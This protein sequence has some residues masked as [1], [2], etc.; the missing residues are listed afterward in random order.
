MTD[1]GHDGG[2]EEAREWVEAVLALQNRIYAK[3]KAIGFLEPGEEDR[4]SHHLAEV[5]FGGSVFASR[6]MPSFLISEGDDLPT[7][8]VDLVEDVREIK[9]AIEAVEGEPLKQMRLPEIADV[10]EHAA[11]FAPMQHRPDIA[12]EQ[13]QAQQGADGLQLFHLEFAFAVILSPS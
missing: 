6:M 13:Q 4:I 5:A 11:G 10:I 7:A 8:A 2:A 12:G 3:L 9:E 1:G